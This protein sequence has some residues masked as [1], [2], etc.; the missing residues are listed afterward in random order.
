MKQQLY[1][2]MHTDIGM[3]RDHVVM[4]PYDQE[5]A[6]HA[7]A[8]KAEVAGLPMFRESRKPGTSY[9]RVASRFN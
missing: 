1:Y 6:K 7:Q 8:F 9:S 5:V 3:D 2:F 4:V